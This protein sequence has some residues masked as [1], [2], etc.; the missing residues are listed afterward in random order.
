MS[1]VATAAKQPC[2]STPPHTQTHA[3]FRSVLVELFAVVIAMGD[4]HHV[5]YI[6]YVNFNLLICF[7]VCF[8]R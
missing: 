7:I 6:T 3:R 4:G 1:I 2:L 8:I 5:I